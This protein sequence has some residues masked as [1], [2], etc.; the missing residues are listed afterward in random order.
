VTALV[1]ILRGE[2]PV[3]HLMW[4]VNWQVFNCSSFCSS[5]KQDW[6]SWKPV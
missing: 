1:L 5:F 4:R 6:P 3:L 2:V